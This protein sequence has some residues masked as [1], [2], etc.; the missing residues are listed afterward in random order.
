MVDWLRHL[1]TGKDN[2]THDVV[3]WGALLG[4]L[5]ALGLTVY[6]VVIHAAHFNLQE[7]GLGMGALLG[8]TGAALG[9]KKDT[10]PDGKQ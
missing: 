2:Q 10:E 9:L 1:V 8:A 7:F 6:D 3:R 5:Q 4:T